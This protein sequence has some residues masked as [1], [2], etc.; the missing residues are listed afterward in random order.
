MTTQCNEAKLI[1]HDLDS[2][3]VVGRFDGGEITSDAGAVLL[4]E[5]E[6]R[7]RV[8]R[9]MS[10]CFKDHRDP[11]RLEHTVESLVKQRVM[12]LCL[13]YEDLNDH[14][15]LCRDRMMALV[16]ESDDVNGERRHRESDRGKAL[17]GKSTLNRME[18]RPEQD[19]HRRYRKIEADTA[20]LDA[21][22]VDVFLE[23]H[24]GDVPIEV[25]LDVDATDDPLHGEQE[26][27]FFHGY[28]KSYCYLPLYI[29]CGHHL[30]SARLRTADQ[31]GAQG[32]VEELEG[33]VGRIRA[34]W[35]GVGIVVRGDS[36][37]CRDELMT[38]CEEQGVEYV[39]GLAKNP[40]LTKMIGEEMAE[41]KR[42]HE[43]SGES[44]RVFAE[45][46]YRTRDT[47]SCERRVV[48]KAE[49]MSG[50]ENPRFIVT[51][52]A[53]EQWAGCELYEQGYCARGEMEN[54]IKE[55][56]LNLFADRTS[57][58]QMQ[59]NQMRLYFASF[60][61]VLMH[62]LRRM[63]LVGTELAR[64]QCGTIREKVLKIGAQI[65]V[66]VRKVWLSM[67]ESYPREG[68]FRAVLARLEAIPLCC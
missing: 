29:F 18:L 7:T 55:Q 51:S 48:A 23:A 41:A 1:F 13:G 50:G 6:K 19:K 38:W 31:D 27:R 15:E 58:H 62:G 33:I 21:L 68:L 53:V 34:R 56:Q 47:W 60:A 40:R 57:S 3:E 37:F 61:Y 24:E 52:Y 66:S 30:L 44:E 12:G 32:V 20:A 46:R 17:A 10:E 11:E 8:L 2:R 5:V 9:R 54:R 22:L 45:L 63:G 42:L 65:R 64:A 39:L 67:S 35:P 25:V 59:A 43:A 26:G 14:D 36:G 4:R 49:H 28:Y 16:C